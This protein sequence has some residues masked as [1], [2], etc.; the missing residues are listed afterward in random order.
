MVN[1]IK[2]P[3]RRV[4][5]CMPYEVRAHM[6]KSDQFGRPQPI[7]EPCARACGTQHF[8]KKEKRDTLQ[9]KKKNASAHPEVSV[10]N[11]VGC[12]RNKLPKYI[13]LVTPLPL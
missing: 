7:L 5:T 11:C 4:A 13:I 10:A 9:E 1:G 6:Q 8:G 2:M 12:H 3:N